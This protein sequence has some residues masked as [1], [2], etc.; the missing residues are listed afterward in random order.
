MLEPFA[1]Q[2]ESLR[3]SAP[4]ASLR[5]IALV[6]QGD[7]DTEQ[8]LLWQLCTALQG[9][10]YPPVVLDGT[11]RESAQHPGLQNLLDHAHWPSLDGGSTGWQVMPAATGLASLAR[12]SHGDN[13]AL[14]PLAPLF[15]AYSVLLV[16]GRIELLMPVLAGSG[17]QPVLAVTSPRASVMRG[18]RTFKQLLLQGRLTPTL[19]AMA[20]TPLRNAEAAARSAGKT[21]QKCAMTHLGCHTDLTTVRGEGA[22]GGRADD[23]HRLAL[24]LLENAVTVDSPAYASQPAWPPVYRPRQPEFAQAF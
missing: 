17:V 23:A 10:G 20:T 1:D 3:H 6:S 19:V 14:Q 15:R 12:S 2:G 7:S 22:A 16:Y 5:L 13:M 24:R 9:F 11:S 18:Y 21:L 4:Q 8:P